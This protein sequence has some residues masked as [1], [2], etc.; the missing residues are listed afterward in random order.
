MKRGGIRWFKLNR[1]LHRDIGYFCV[2]LTIVFAVSGI[3]V[4]HIH[5]WNPNYQV[6]LKTVTLPAQPW[7]QLSDEQ[8]V[9]QM[10]LVADTELPIKTSYWSSPTE[11]KLFLQDGSN[12]VLDVERHQLQLEF[13]QPRYLLRAFNKLHLNEGHRAWVI[14]SDLYAAMLLFLSLSALF[15]VKGKHSPWRQRSLLLIAGIALP[16]VFVLL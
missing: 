14:F 8:R 16:T 1:A 2:G 3:A 11:F 5:D 13:I 4:N 10:L 6:E 15:M 9:Q 7:R 12:M